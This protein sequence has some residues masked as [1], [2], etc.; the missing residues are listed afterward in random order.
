MENRKKDDKKQKEA[1]KRRSLLFFSLNLSTFSK[2]QRKRFSI[3][4]DDA[5]AGKSSEMRRGV[6]VDVKSERNWVVVEEQTSHSL[7]ADTDTDDVDYDVEGEEEDDS[8]VN[9]LASNDLN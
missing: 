9:S 2:I 6:E 7:S 4:R 5:M 3:T 8:K 1:C